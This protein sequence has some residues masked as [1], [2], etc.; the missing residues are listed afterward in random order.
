MMPRWEESAAQPSCHRESATDSSP[1][2]AT[3][4]QNTSKSSL[5]L[6]PHF[7]SKRLGGPGPH[8]T[9]PSPLHLHHHMDQIDFIFGA[10][11]L[12]SIFSCLLASCYPFPPPHSLPNHLPRFLSSPFILA[13]NTTQ[14]ATGNNCSGGVD[15]AAKA[16]KRKKN[17]RGLSK[18]KIARIFGQKKKRRFARKLKAIFVYATQN[19]VPT[20]CTSLCVRTRCCS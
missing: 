12:C 4:G 10:K 20:P 7:S 6:R 15:K 19:N 2:F 5:D 9:P 11:T 1:F 17:R 3:T 16:R 14:K 18:K 13:L 8:F